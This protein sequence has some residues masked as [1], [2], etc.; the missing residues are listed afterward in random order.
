[1]S[2]GAGKDEVGYC[3]TA[4]G[5]SLGYLLIRRACAERHLC[6][7]DCAAAALAAPMRPSWVRQRDR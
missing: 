2:G 4:T 1:M 3:G 6:D 7:P 5:T